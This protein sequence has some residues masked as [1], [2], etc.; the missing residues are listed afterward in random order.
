MNTFFLQKTKITVIFLTHLVHYV[1][2]NYNNRTYLF[3][4]CVAG[5]SGKSDFVIDIVDPGKLLL[6]V[7]GVL[8]ALVNFL[9]Y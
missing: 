5:D 7:M 3:N 8:L 2:T 4:S 6:S 1:Y 9:K